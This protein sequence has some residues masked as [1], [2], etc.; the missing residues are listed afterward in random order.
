MDEFISFIHPESGMISKCEEGL[1]CWWFCG[2]LKG[3]G[4]QPNQPPLHTPSH[5]HCVSVCVET[6]QNPPN[7]VEVCYNKRVTNG[8][9]LLF[10]IDSIIRL[11]KPTNPTLRREK[12]WKEIDTKMIRERDTTP[13]NPKFNHDNCDWMFDTLADSRHVEMMSKKG[14]KPGYSTK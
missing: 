3:G 10:N 13:I 11:F 8:E 9:T 6:H 7:R 5:Y 12:N 4:N 14:Y 2:I 1:I